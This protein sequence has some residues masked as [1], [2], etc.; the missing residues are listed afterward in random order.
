MIQQK[1][2]HKISLNFPQ[3]FIIRKYAKIRFE[4]RGEKIKKYY[5][6]WIKDNVFAETL[7]FIFDGVSRAKTDL[8]NKY[9]IYLVFGSFYEKHFIKNNY[10]RSF[11]EKWPKFAHISKY[12]LM[13]PKIGSIIYSPILIARELFHTLGK[14]P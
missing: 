9:M 6:Y 13:L 11:C 8:H 7:G 3:L 2:A 5:K 12:K 4:N 14:I 1:L 10:F